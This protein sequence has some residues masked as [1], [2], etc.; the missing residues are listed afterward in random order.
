MRKLQPYAC[1]LVIVGIAA[2]SC[3]RV[4]R[5]SAAQA[6]SSRLDTILHQMDAASAK[7]QNA[8]ADF[9]KA[10]FEKI[11]HDTTTETGKIYFLRKGSTTQMG[12]KSALH[13][14]EFKDG[15]VR[16]YNP[17]S[18]HLDQYSVAGKNQALA[19]TFLTLGFGGSGKDLKDKWTITDKGSEQMSDGAST[20]AVEQL[21][22]VSKD[23]GVKQNY[24]HITI[25]LDPVRD[26]A[27]K[28]IFYESSGNT[29]TATYKNIVWNA[30]SVDT[31]SFA[32]KCKS[33]K[34]D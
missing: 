6:D 33:N 19:Q 24:P 34:C 7:F 14:V 31:S 2:A 30:K 20:V 28:Q 26:V 4:E 29:N 9:E 23:P 12:A 17:G 5:V 27:L 15:N 11:V 8:Q 21:D 10:E 3:C 22:L 16:V 25:W 32:I 18:N 1:A 13:I